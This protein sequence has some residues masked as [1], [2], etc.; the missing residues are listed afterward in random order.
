MIVN[1]KKIYEHPD[2]EEILSKLV[3]GISEND[4]HEWL[5]SKYVN[6]N[7]KKFVI[8]ESTLKSFKDDYL[9]VYKTIQEDILKTKEASKD[10]I[11]DQL[12]LSIKN[13]S[14]YKNKMIDL[15]TKELDIREIVTRLAINIENRIG[16]VFDTIQENPANINT[17]LDRIFIE[18]ADTL[19][20][21]LEKYHKFTTIPQEQ[22][23]QHNVTLQVVDQHIYVFHD[24]I[25]EILSQIDLDK[26][27]YFME[28]FNKRIKKLKA[29]SEK[30][31]IPTEMRLAE[32]N[33]INEVINKKL[34]SE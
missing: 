15:A 14:A 6:F 34:S 18:Y 31:I 26:S 7:E 20:N 2:R 17:K 1:F 8:A 33:M 28:E 4:I 27:M 5:K 25:K 12:D 22:V 13:N 19:G 9:D 11:L 10:G 30:D 24:L 23:V 3:I 32:A 29:P 21:I 16:Q